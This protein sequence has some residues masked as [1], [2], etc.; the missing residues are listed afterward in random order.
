MKD[1]YD[2]DVDWDHHFSMLHPR[3]RQEV[4]EMAEQW[5]ISLKDTLICVADMFVLEAQ[6]ELVMRWMK[7]G[8]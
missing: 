3:T 4:K 7:E 2:H 6:P 8:G 1:F 5:G